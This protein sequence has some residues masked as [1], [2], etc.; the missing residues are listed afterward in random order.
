VA[1]TVISQHRTVTVHAGIPDAILASFLERAGLGWQV[2]GCPVVIS[3]V[4]ISFRF[5]GHE[6]LPIPVLPEI[7]LQGRDCIIR[8]FH[9]STQSA[10]V[11]VLRVVVRF[12]LCTALY[13]AIAACGQQG[14]LTR[15]EEP[16]VISS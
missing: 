10:G 12:W 14:P 16:A 7:V 6:R 15:P 4:F 3:R 8:I 2:C 1:V 5:D 13:L 11:P 9:L